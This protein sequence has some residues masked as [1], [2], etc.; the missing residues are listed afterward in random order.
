MIWAVVILHRESLG[1]NADISNWWSSKRSAALWMIIS[2]PKKVK[3]DGPR[4]TLD[5]IQNVAKPTTIDG[6]EIKKS[7][8]N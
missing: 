5:K 4:S 8:E 7:S 1:E 3:S 6:S 2:V